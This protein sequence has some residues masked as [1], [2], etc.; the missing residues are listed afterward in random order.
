HRPGFLRAVRRPVVDHLGEPVE[1]PSVVSRQGFLGDRTRSPVRCQYLLVGKVGLNEP[2]K[3]LT[4]DSKIAPSH[5]PI[6][7]KN[8]MRIP[9]NACLSSNVVMVLARSFAAGTIDSL[10]R[11]GALWI[12]P[13]GST[14]GVSRC[15][16]SG[17]HREAVTSGP[18]RLTRPSERAQPGPG[19]RW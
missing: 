13:S 1:Q 2:V 5:R 16:P 4:L 10:P 19:H 7:P 18:R 3:V 9:V 17:R 11:P 6:H 15:F 12:A 8:R 14:S